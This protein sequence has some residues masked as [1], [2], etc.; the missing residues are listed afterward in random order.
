MQSPKPNGIWPSPQSEMVLTEP[1]WDWTWSHPGPSCGSQLYNCNQAAKRVD[2]FLCSAGMPE[3]GLSRATA[4][5]TWI[6]MLCCWN[7][8]KSIPKEKNNRLFLLSSALGKRMPEAFCKPR[9]KET[10]LYNQIVSVLTSPCSSCPVPP[11]KRTCSAPGVYGRMLVKWS[12]CPGSLQSRLAVWSMLAGL[13]LDAW[14]D[15][16]ALWQYRREKI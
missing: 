8:G 3:V 10:F 16:R 11:Q 14:A 1:D 12:S 2:V 7:P 15:K 4:D 6:C 9:Q 13:C 5:H